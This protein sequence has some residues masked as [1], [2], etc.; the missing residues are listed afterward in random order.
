MGRHKG[1]ELSNPREHFLRVAVHR[2][3]C[4]A[5]FK[6]T[7][8]LLMLFSCFLEIQVLP[9]VQ[10]AMTQHREP[11][12][13]EYARFYGVSVDHLAANPFDLITP[14]LKRIYESHSTTEN[15]P[16][17]DFSFPEP[18]LEK[19]LRNEKLE[20]GRD[21]ARF[22]SNIIKDASTKTTN[23]IDWDTYLPKRRRV[24]SLKADEL[25][26]L[27]TVHELDM[28]SFGHERITLDPATLKLHLEKTQD[29]NDEGIVFPKDFW[30]LP[31]RVLEKVKTEK[32]D[33]TREAFMLIQ[34]ARRSGDHF[35]NDIRDEF[36]ERTL[37]YAKV[38]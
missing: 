27:K 22:L 16:R 35:T 7:G 6:T 34:E 36:Y 13:L 29:E 31:G 11:S 15:T 32:L 4:T 2:Q 10:T 3:L 18:P 21:G 26:L 9:E 20:I 24:R 8:S 19:E 37:S 1:P 38:C 17:V 25:P 33:C 12:L 23:P 14:D 5:A 28:A 30:K